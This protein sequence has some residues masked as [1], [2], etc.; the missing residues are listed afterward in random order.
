MTDFIWKQDAIEHA[1]QCDPNESCGIVAFKNN[2]EKYYPC[3]N[4]KQI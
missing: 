3:K 2:K 1:K 4:I